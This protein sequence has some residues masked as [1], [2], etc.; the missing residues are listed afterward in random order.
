MLVCHSFLDLLARSDSSFAGSLLVRTEW[1][2]R[3][4]ACSSMVTGG[5]HASPHR[6]IHEESTLRR[7]V[8]DSLCANSC[9]FP[10]CALNWGA[11]SCCDVPA[12]HA[13]AVHAPPALASVALAVT[14][15]RALSP[16]SSVCLRST[17]SHVWLD[18]WAARHRGQ[19]DA[20][21]V[22][23]PRRVAS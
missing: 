21:P 18:I 4:V 1:Q 23:A 6:K 22:A 11:R 13:V 3:V 16:L 20:L 17:R 9:L 7:C 19:T 8:C 15:Q 2:V 5:P 14:H 12:T 10:C